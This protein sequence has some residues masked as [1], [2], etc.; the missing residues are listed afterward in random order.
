[1]VKAASSGIGISEV[2]KELMAEAKLVIYTDSVAAKGIVMRRGAGRVKHLSVKQLWVQ[3]V[4]RD[5]DVYICKVPR[6]LN[7]ADL[8]TH[9][10]SRQAHDAHLGRLG[11]VRSHRRR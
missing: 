9:S 5:R 10:C 1:M 11:V 3:E 2:L 4:V 8:L 7:P 6:D